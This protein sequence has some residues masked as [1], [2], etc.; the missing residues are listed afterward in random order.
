VIF[1]FINKKS[2][3]F[4]VAII[5]IGFSALG[6]YLWDDGVFDS[7]QT[8]I[9]KLTSAIIP[10]SSVV[11]DRNGEKIGEYYNFY[12]IFVPY[13]Q[14]PKPMIEALLAIEDR[15]FFEHSGVNWK[16]MGRAILSTLTSGRFYVCC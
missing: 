11:F 15:K 2:L 4:A 14:I 9:A 6:L 13:D 10:D 3:M 8:Q 12:H 5:F 7:E 1:R 16:S